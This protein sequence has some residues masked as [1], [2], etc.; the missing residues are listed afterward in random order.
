MS[1]RAIPNSG[2]VPFFDEEAVRA[3]LR[4]DELLAAMERALADFSS[5]T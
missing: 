5:N 3:V 2:S 4:F 1:S